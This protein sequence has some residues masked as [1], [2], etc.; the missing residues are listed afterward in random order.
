MS[1]AAVADR[2]ACGFI[3]GSGAQYS[4]IRHVSKHVRHR[5]IDIFR[6]RAL[7][8]R[9]LLSAVTFAVV[10]L[11]SLITLRFALHSNSCL[12]LFLTHLWTAHALGNDEIRRFLCAFPD[13]FEC[14]NVTVKGSSGRPLTMSVDSV[15]S[16]SLKQHN[17][18]SAAPL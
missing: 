8:Q 6:W 13:L 11:F 9:S 12:A 15:S 7:Q 4:V 18:Q 16:T 3:Q 2:D 5:E 17:R 1:A 10:F 14:L